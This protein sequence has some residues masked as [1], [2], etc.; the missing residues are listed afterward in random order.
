VVGEPQLAEDQEAEGIRAERGQ[1]P[2]ERGGEGRPVQARRHHQVDGEQGDRDG[3][4]G[5]GEGQ[6][7]AGLDRAAPQQQ[8]ALVALSPLLPAP[9]SPPVT[10]GTDGVPQPGARSCGAHVVTSGFGYSRL[11]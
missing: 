5:V 3:E 7:P 10:P 1:E 4:D 11:E 6:D 9:G 2:V 8:L